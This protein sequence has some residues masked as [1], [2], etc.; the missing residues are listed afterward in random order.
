MHFSS[1]TPSMTLS[2]DKKVKDMSFSISYK[3]YPRDNLIRVEVVGSIT[4]ESILEFYNE[5]IYQSNYSPEMNCLWDSR[6]I[7]VVEGSVLA[8][9]DAAEF[10]NN[11]GLFAKNTRTAILID[12]EKK[13][14]EKYTQGF[15][16]MASALN[17]EHKI[18]TDIEDKELA[19]YLGVSII[20]ALE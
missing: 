9:S 13:N 6:G 2:K 12:K 16:L 18:F 4:F 8:F 14:I 1:T 3:L 15:I 11:K 19:S 20:P 5:L 10:I 17:I 7:D